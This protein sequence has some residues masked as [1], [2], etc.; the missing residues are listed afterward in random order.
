MCHCHA[1]IADPYLYIIIRMVF[2]KLIN[3]GCG[4]LCGMNKKCSV[5]AQTCLGISCVVISSN[6]KW[7]IVVVSDGDY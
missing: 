4:A 7:H 5:M 3:I 2:L 6:K 1:A